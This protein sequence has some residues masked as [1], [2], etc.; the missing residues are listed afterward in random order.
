MIEHKQG[1]A[2]TDQAGFHK[3]QKVTLRISENEQ[4]K[5]DESF[6]E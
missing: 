3:G 6:N 5:F 2:K 4:K 1:R